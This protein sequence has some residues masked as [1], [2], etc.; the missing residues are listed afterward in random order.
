[1]L[2]RN[3]EWDV[4]PKSRKQTIFLMHFV[5]E[6]TEQ[7]CPRLD[8]LR[9]LLWGFFYDVLAEQRSPWLT[10]L[11]PLGLIWLVKWG[12]GL[13]FAC[14]SDMSY[15]GEILDLSWVTLG[16]CGFIWLILSHFLALWLYLVNP[17]SFWW[18]PLFS[19]RL[20]SVFLP[21]IAS[22]TVWEKQKSWRLKARN[23]T[24]CMCV[25]EREVIW[26]T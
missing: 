16:P 21:N 24:A 4:Q 3:S 14:A 22:V 13:G 12:H 5:T 11:G 25:T 2:G 6:L 19:I 1:M 10:A 7:D 26:T 23:N 18:A 17:E 20:M 15:L 8:R 9:C